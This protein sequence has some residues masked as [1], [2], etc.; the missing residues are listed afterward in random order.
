MTSQAAGD[1]AG[2]LVI[3]VPEDLVEC[4]SAAMWLSWDLTHL[5][6]DRPPWGV[7]EA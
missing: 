2:S 3:T 5:W 4:L 6:T 1:D 7:P